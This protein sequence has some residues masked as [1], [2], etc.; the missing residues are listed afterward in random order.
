LAGEV[1]AE[2]IQQGVPFSGVQ[3]A[4]RRCVGIVDVETPNQL[5]VRFNHDPQ[6]DVRGRR[7]VVLLKFAPTA[8]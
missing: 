7:H 4:I 5:G 1:S 3:T 6:G 8:W 2:R